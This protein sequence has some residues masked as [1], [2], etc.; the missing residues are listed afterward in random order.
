MSKVILIAVS[1]GFGGYGD[2]LFALKLAEQIKKYYKDNLGIDNP[3]EIK[4]VTQASGQQKI[5]NLKGDEEFS[6]EVLT[7][8]EL[9]QKVDADELEVESIIEG[10]VFRSRLINDINLAIQK[11]QHPVP[12]VMMPEY[13]FSDALHRE[14]MIPHQQF[15]QNLSKIAYRGIVYTG[16]NTS[17]KEKGII[18][19]DNLINPDEPSILATR[20]EEKIK[21]A[22][23]GE[24]G[25]EAY[26][27][28]TDMY[29]QYSHDTFPTTPKTS[30]AERF[31][32]MQRIYAKDSDKNQDV[33]MVGK[34]IL[35]KRQALEKVKEQLIDD[36]FTKI[37]F[38]NADTKE[39]EYLHGNP[40]SKGRHYRVV[41]TAGMSH[42]SMI[43][44]QALSGDL[45]GATG[46]QS[47]GEAVSGDKILVYECLSHKQLLRNQ[48]YQQ[49]KN[50]DPECAQALDL[51]KNAET[52]SDYRRLELLLTPAMKSKLKHLSSS[53]RNTV[54]LAKFSAIA[55]LPT[56]LLS[57]QIARG[58]IP[59]YSSDTDLLSPFENTLRAGNFDAVSYVIEHHTSNNDDRRE[60][61]ETFTR[62]NHEGNTLLSALRTA[63]PEAAETSQASYL[64]ARF[65]I[66]KYKPQPGS[67]RE[68]MFNAYKEL[69]STF[70]A[71]GQHDE[72]ALIGLMLLTTKNIS[73]EYSFLSP[74]KGWFF[75]SQFYSNLEDTLKEL[76]VN[77]K[78]ITPQEKQRYHT[79][80]A[81]VIEN[82]PNLIANEYILQSLSKEAN[83]DLPKVPPLL[84]KSEA[85]NLL[86][87]EPKKRGEN[88][89]TGSS[90]IYKTHSTPLGKG[91]WGSVY[92]ARHY[93]QDQEGLHISS[94]LAIK[95]MPASGKMVMNKEMQM[96]KAVYPHEHFE[97]FV[98]NGQACLAMPLFSGVPLDSYLYE[99]VELSKETRRE[100]ACSL[101]QD[102]Q[103]I[104]SA[105]I[106]HNDLKP[107][108]I[109]YDPVAK[110]MHIIDF[111]C[112]EN[113]GTML[114]YKSFD[115]AIFA[116][117]IP[118][119][120]M[121]GA[122]ANSQMDVFSLTPVIAELLG[123][124]KKE[125]VGARMERA[126]AKVNN[127]NLV[128]AIRQAFRESESLEI[129]LFSNRVYS[130]TRT[131]DFKS[132]VKYYVDDK[133]DFSPYTELL[134]EE[135]IE[136]LN[137]MQN[138]DPAQRPDIEEVLGA[139]KQQEATI[140]L[141]IKQ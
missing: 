29:F 112:A 116:F 59:P 120:Y 38:Y 6:V 122:A 110:E 101:L 3:P 8:R 108:N 17:T 41:Y 51:L 118:P 91:G 113:A 50:L 18:L 79:A 114:K 42:S 44:A 97:Q 39:E 69:I 5:R 130:L 24:Q 134:G 93:S 62:K 35:S 64:V 100:M 31:L 84:S 124:N 75:G 1:D 67:T 34:S 139:L 23:P 88:V 89:L 137:N 85:L 92:T 90:G 37:S 138:K 12:L 32:K 40:D 106:T 46:D 63:K 136:L 117:E 107:K 133:Y 72:D 95:M 103:K 87:T 57:Q 61:C 52:E 47:F 30:P 33:L 2:F 49:L 135:I 65:N 45:L 56:E 74:R 140:P 21:A 109:L 70:S 20:L 4:L 73:R 82:N 86:Q 19:S 11:Q 126:L 60:F 104:H 131:E 26:Q 99:H 78:T 105:G 125:F 132:F 96:F 81:R 128:Q 22:L 83:I 102:L 54:E 28:S 27:A 94:P 10:P 16:F 43:A 58:T 123:A 77:L 14:N 71:L 36:G 7:P 66:E 119:E 15:R 121:N 55:A 115:T 25:I 76:G 80:L 48:Y 98:Q 68:T 141:E 9:K 129:A 53:F 127:P 111:G 13:A